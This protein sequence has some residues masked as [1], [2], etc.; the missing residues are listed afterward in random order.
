MITHKTSD[1]N[2]DFQHLALQNLF[3]L[4]GNNEKGA[5]LIIVLL[6][7]ATLSVIA[8]GLTELTQLAAARSRNEQARTQLHWKMIGAQTLSE[9]LLTAALSQRPESMSLDDPWAVQPIR[10]DALATTPDERGE[11]SFRDAGNC[12][13]LNSLLDDSTATSFDQNVEEFALLLSTI[14][15]SE[16]DARQL[17]FVIRDWIDEDQQTTP[18]GAE[19]DIYLRLPVPYRTGGTLLASKSELRSMIGVDAVFMTIIAPFLC[20]HPQTAPS[21]VNVNMLRVAD[22]PLLSSLF[23]GALSLTDA[24][25]IIENR[26]IGGF[27]NITEVLTLPILQSALENSDLV[28]TN[29]TSRLTL[30]SQFLEGRLEM[31]YGKTLLQVSMLFSV[32][33]A[34]RLRLVSRQFGSSF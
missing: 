34:N 14:G 24:E 33:N 28:P 30:R 8:L 3:P 2:A 16:N 13:N 9:R 15:I 25:A 12:F 32:D 31:E 20:A 5:A 26:P 4:K 7:V 10:L 19:D 18:G 29:A 22:A 27:E 11:I 17:A 23:G 1:C 21:S 6:L